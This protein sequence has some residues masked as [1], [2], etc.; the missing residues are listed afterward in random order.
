MIFYVIKKLSFLLSAFKRSSWRV[1]QKPHQWPTTE[2]I[3]VHDNEAILRPNRRLLSPSSPSHL[4]SPSHALSPS[5]L[6]C[7][8]RRPPLN[9]PHHPGPLKSTSLTR[10][11]VLIAWHPVQLPRT[12]SS[13]ASTKGASPAVTRPSSVVPTTATVA[14]PSTGPAATLPALTLSACR[15]RSGSHGVRTAW[16]WWRRPRAPPPLPPRQWSRSPPCPGWF[17]ATSRAKKTNSEEITENLFHIPYTCVLGRLAG[18]LCVRF[19]RVFSFR[20]FSPH[21][22]PDSREHCLWLNQKL[23]GKWKWMSC[24]VDMCWWVIVSS[25]ISLLFLFHYMAASD[26]TIVRCQIWLKS[27]RRDIDQLSL[28]LSLFCQMMFL[29]FP[30]FAMEVPPRGFA[31]NT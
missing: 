26:P 30:F 11:L 14:V 17:P 20:H 24:S 5:H 27:K 1:P 25:N 13:A 28:S 15:T 22:F 7:P 12:A 6:N 29:S 4:K 18:R 19:E 23:Y 2:E 21:I 16:P 8:H 3:K 9:R 31:C 10:W